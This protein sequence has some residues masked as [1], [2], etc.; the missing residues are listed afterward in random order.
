M[1]YTHSGNPQGFELETPLASSPIIY[2]QA[3]RTSS[4][5]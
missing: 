5:C 4:G 2:H 3:K 1:I